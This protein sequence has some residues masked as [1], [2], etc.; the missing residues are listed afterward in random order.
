MS[1]STMSQI[2]RTWSSIGRPS[3]AISDGLVVTP[4]TTPHP[5]P[6]FSSSRLAVSRKNFIDRALPAQIPVYT[7]RR[8]EASPTP[9]SGR[10]RQRPTPPLPPRSQI[11]AFLSCSPRPNSALSAPPRLVPPTPSEPP[12]FS[13]ALLSCSPRP[14]SALSAPPRLVPPH[15]LRAARRS[16]ERRVG[17]ECR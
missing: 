17:K 15:N 7:A 10:S 8:F 6:F 14:N 2:M 4:S 1:P 5:A 16:E 11:F 13:N 9:P 3:L 12:A